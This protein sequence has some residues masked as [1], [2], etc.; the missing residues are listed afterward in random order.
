[1]LVQGRNLQRDQPGTRGL[2]T[3]SHRAHPTRLS[4][5]RGCWSPAA[6]QA[7]GVP[8]REERAQALWSQG[9]G[10]RWRG[11]LRGVP[12]CCRSAPRAWWMKT[13]SNS[14][15]L[16]SSLKEVS[17]RP[18]PQFLQVPASLWQPCRGW[19]SL[20]WGGDPHPHTPA[21]AS[22]ARCCLHPAGRGGLQ[23][24]TQQQYA[25]GAW[26]RGSGGPDTPSLGL[27]L[28]RFHHLCALPLQR[29]RCRP[30]RGHPL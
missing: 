29:L 30:E 2:T 17:L 9:V 15:T 3:P 11:L 20:L 5:A 26:G 14:F 24:R 8:Q 28:P 23:P 1:M 10:E 19:A 18:G 13:R 27:G 16:S 21:P 25:E 7:A 12:S 6:P 22:L 4:P